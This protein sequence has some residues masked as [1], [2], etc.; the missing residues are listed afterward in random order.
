MLSY[1]WIPT[2]H[3]KMLPL[4]WR[5]MK[6]VSSKCWYLL[7]RLHGVTAQETIIWTHTA[8]RTSHFITECQFHAVFCH[9]YTIVPFLFPVILQIW[10]WY[11][12][13]NSDLIRIDTHEVSPHL[14]VQGLVKKMINTM[15]TEILLLSIACK[16]NLLSPDRV[17]IDRVWIGNRIYCTLQN[18]NYN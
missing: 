3:R 10:Y 2:F 9:F 7:I 17:T 13:I 16:S 1:Q 4:S 14:T 18:C 11:N 8:V 5:W 6:Y 15:Y 12:S